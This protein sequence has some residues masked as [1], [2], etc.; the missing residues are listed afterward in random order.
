VEETISERM[1][2]F[3]RLLQGGSLR[4][5]LSVKTVA[6]AL[7]ATLFGL[8]ST[9]P[10]TAKK[11]VPQYRAESSAYVIQGKD[12][13]TYVTQNRS[14]R[15]VDVLG[16][17][18][19]YEAVLLLEETYHNERADGIEGVRG[20]TTVRA[21]TLEPGRQRELRW[22]FHEAGNEGIVQDRLFRVTAWGCCD[23]PVTYS[24]YNL[25]TGKKLYV[26]NSD[27]LEIRGDGDGPQASR[28]VAFGYSGQ[29]QLSQPPR[30]QYGTDKNVAQRLSVISPRQYYDAPQMF[31]SRSGTLE[32]TLDLRGSEL[33][34]IIVLKYADGVEL[35]IPVEADA[36]RLEKAV[37]PEGYS[38]RVEK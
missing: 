37:L 24:Y 31:V 15:F 17:Q 26:S 16:D 29:S 10:G 9:D 22:T 21:W 27:L 36:V 18:G 20:D 5:D 35:H 1:I 14:F 6:A 19:N 33:T 32:K 13:S 8:Q 3:R 28:L 7:V 2:S 38:L 25:L 23:V 30:L 12:A 11:T 4:G 34:F